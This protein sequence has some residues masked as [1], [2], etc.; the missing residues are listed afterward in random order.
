VIRNTKLNKLDKGLEENKNIT[1]L[2]VKNK[3]ERLEIEV[4]Q[5][6]SHQ[7]A[8]Q[9]FTSNTINQHLL[10]NQN[11]YDYDNNEN[12]SNNNIISSNNKSSLVPNSKTNKVA[13]A[14][15]AD[16]SDLSIIKIEKLENK[17]NKESKANL[18]IFV[19]KNIKR[20]AKENLMRSLAKEKSLLKNKHVY[21]A[22]HLYNNSNLEG[23][24]Y[25]KD[26]DVSRALRY[27][28]KIKKD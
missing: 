5:T 9:D 21:K 19:Q 4:E 12:H 8:L 18:E 23:L 22:Q 7:L 25:E 16:K 10:Q 13:K 2:S 27:E 24:L 11:D 28:K 17:G 3:K 6:K 15:K 1:L 26:T 14:D 20:T